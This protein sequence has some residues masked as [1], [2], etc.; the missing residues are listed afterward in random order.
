MA[1]EQ[2]G[3][4]RNKDPQECLVPPEGRIEESHSQFVGR[5]HSLTSCT[6]K[7]ADWGAFQT[8]LKTAS[9]KLFQ[10]CSQR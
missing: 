1:P 9:P 5:V 10:V 2:R 4:G 7:S 8:G 3:H 6:R